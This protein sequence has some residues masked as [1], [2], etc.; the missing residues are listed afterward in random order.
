MASPE[1]ERPMASPSNPVLS[2]HAI[3]PRPSGGTSPVVLPPSSSNTSR[4]VVT[5]HQCLDP[6]VLGERRPAF[7]SSGNRNRPKFGRHGGGNPRHSNYKYR[8][9]GGPRFHQN[10]NVSF[11]GGDQPSAAT[12]G[13]DDSKNIISTGDKTAIT[14]LLPG[15]NLTS[16][17]HSITQPKHFRGAGALRKRSYSF[18]E[19]MLQYYEKVNF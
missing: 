16:Q 19:G 6:N 1:V 10:T 15:G 8:S 4:K 9:S 17:S 11:V 3:S 12:H 13:R 14:T 7:V 5:F 2:P 18:S